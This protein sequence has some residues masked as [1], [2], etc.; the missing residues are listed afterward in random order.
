MSLSPSGHS[1]RQELPLTAAAHLEDGARW[2][3]VA[4]EVKNTV[5]LRWMLSSDSEENGGKL[6]SLMLV[7]RQNWEER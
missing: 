6:C 3:K 2:N 1:D 7:M 4:A 5:E